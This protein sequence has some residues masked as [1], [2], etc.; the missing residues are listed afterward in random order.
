MN[1][2]NNSNNGN[3]LYVR[4]LGLPEPSP[5]LKYRGTYLKINITTTYN[6]NKNLI[7]MFPDPVL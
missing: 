1:S 7:F 6:S 5:K 3:I 4:E 2:K